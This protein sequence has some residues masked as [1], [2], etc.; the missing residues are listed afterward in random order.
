MVKK[1]IKTYL[2]LLFLVFIIVVTIDAILI[3]RQ[4]ATASFN[5]LCSRSFSPHSPSSCLFHGV[6]ATFLNANGLL[7]PSTSRCFC[8]F[9]FSRIFPPHFPYENLPA[10]WFW[11]DNIVFLSHA[12]WSRKTSRESELYYCGYKRHILHTSTSKLFI[13]LQK[14]R[15]FSPHFIF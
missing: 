7:S 8:N 2:H 12:M 10:N 1:D 3:W 9:L 15:T 4:A 13:V 11:H 5:D 14:T 6:I